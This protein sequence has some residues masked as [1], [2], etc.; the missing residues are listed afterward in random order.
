MA[1]YIVHQSICFL[2]QLVQFV[3]VMCHTKQNTK[4]SENSSRVIPLIPMNN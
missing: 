1:E 4:S 2:E 3:Q